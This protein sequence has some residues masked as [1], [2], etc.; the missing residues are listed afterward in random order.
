MGLRLAAFLA[1]R[2]PNTIPTRTETVKAMNTEKK[3]TV[4]CT[5]VNRLITK[6][7]DRPRITP[8]KPPVKL[9]TTASVRN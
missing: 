9:I 7:M 4:V 1:G 5:S 2:Y 3:V 6:E 8:I